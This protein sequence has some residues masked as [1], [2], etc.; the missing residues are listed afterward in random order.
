MAAAIYNSLTNTQNADS[1]GTDVDVPGETLLERVT[2]SGRTYII[3][4]MDDLG[5]DVRNS[6]R[7]QLTESMLDSYDLVISMAQK[8]YTP[9]WLENN[10]KYHF[11]DIK[12]PGGKNYAAT[13]LALDAIYPK[14]EALI[15]NY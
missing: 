11:W 14:V 2:R 9:V 15:K 8:E 1:A 3:D 6:E 13:Q 5:I 7:T 10:P 12:D 4:V